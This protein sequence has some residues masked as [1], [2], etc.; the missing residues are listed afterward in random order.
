MAV[1][2]IALFEFKKNVEPDQRKAIHQDFCKLISQIDGVESVEIGEPFQNMNSKYTDVALVR[3]RDRAALEAYGPH[4]NHQA[5]GK[6]LTPHIED[7][8]IIDVEV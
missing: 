1:L 6:L 7:A 4:E 2:H 5:V 3:M 8:A